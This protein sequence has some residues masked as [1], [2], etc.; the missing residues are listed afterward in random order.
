MWASLALESS[1]SN[2]VSEPVLQALDYALEYGRNDYETMRW[3]SLIAIRNW[4]WLD[5]AHKIE[6]FGVIHDSLRKNDA[7]VVWWNVERGH[8]SIE[9]YVTALMQAYNFN[10]SWAKRQVDVCRFESAES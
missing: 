1:R 3:L 2:G 6:L 10:E 8:K 5:C 7:I 4:P 9:R